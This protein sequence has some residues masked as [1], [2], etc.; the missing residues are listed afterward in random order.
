MKYRGW[1]TPHD[2]CSLV[3]R[4]NGFSVAYEADGCIVGTLIATASPVS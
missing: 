2:A 4:H 1:S 3:E